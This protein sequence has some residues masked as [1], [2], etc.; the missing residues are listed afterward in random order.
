MLNRI[1]WGKNNYYSSVTI[2]GKRTE[3]PLGQDFAKAEALHAEN[4][5]LIYGRVEPDLAY[6]KRLHSKS[7][8]NARVRKINFLLEL[9]DVQAM[10][11]RSGLLCEV[12]MIPFDMRKEGGYR[13]RPWVP[14]IDRIDSSFGYTPSN[15]RLVCAAVN[16]AMNEFGEEVFYRIAHAVVKQ[17]KTTRK[18]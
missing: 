12:T 18:R 16:S 10:L 8:N 5:H 17:K 3:I 4:M 14:S 13:V 7:K 9:E 15:C 6:A 11:K 1:R 2:N